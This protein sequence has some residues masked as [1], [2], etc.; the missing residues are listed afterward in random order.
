MAELAH[1]TKT[2]KIYKN[3]ET[4]TKQTPVPT[5]SESKI[6]DGSQDGTR[7]T[8]RKDLWNRLVLSLE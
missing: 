3:E 2:Y 1:V 8:R 4:K 6:R 7:K 5:E